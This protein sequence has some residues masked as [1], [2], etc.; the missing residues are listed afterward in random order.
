MDPNASIAEFKAHS[1]CKH[2]GKTNH[3]SDH[4]FGIQRKQ[5]E[6]RLKSFLIQSGLSEEAAQKVVEDAKKKWK[7]QK[8]KGPKAG[9]TKKDAYGP[10]AVSAGAGASSSETKTMQE[11]AESQAKKRK[12]DVAFS[13]VEKI[14]DMLRAAVKDI[15]TL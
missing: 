11:D 14:V 9:P 6:D 1:Q 3:Y 7:H 10:S 15:L 8:Q 2:C 13:E 4:C 5:K 12:R